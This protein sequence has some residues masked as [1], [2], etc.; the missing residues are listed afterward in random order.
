MQ[1]AFL[2]SL[3]CSLLHRGHEDDGE[4]AVKRRIPV[5]ISVARLH[6]QL[7][8]GIQADSDS[9]V[10]GDALLTVIVTMVTASCTCKDVCVEHEI[11]GVDESFTGKELDVDGIPARVGDGVDAVVLVVVVSELFNGRHRNGS[12][13]GDGVCVEGGSE[14]RLLG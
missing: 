3:L 5:R 12:V 8:S 9:S 4:D 14:G 10:A 2:V 11:Q 6:G 7:V 13:G 1:N